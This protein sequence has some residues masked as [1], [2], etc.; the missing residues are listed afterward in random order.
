MS[1]QPSEAL[2]EQDLT[3]QDIAQR[4]QKSD[5]TVR[6]LFAD[7]PGVLRFGNET[8]RNGRRYKRRYYSLR[9]PLSVFLRVQD[10]L[11]QK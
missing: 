11:R 2:P 3:V 1:T 9:I 6:R 7:E 4:W 10:R 8:R 5:D